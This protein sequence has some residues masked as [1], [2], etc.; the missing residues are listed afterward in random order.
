[1][2]RFFAEI[3]YKGIHFAGWQRQVNALTIQEVIETKLSTILNHQTTIVGCGRTDAGV[4]AA[5][6]FFHF[7][8]HFDP[9]SN[10]AYRLN[11]MVG[12]DIAV[13]SIFPVE[14]NLHA[15]FDA[16]SRSYT[17]YLTRQK[18]PFDYEIKTHYPYFD[19]IDVSKLHSTA[20]LI[21]Q[22]SEF[23]PFCKTNSDAETM[24]CNIME[25]RWTIQPEEY[26]YTI[27]A[28]RFLRGMVRLIVGMSIRVAIG[29][30]ELNEV[31]FALEKQRP[32][33]RSWSAPAEGLFL[34][35]V[36]YS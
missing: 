21:T 28:N 3:A 30:I 23:L 29:D 12:P 26:I 32:I 14:E 13:R 6:Y 33:M 15:R 20:S 10:L 8:T 17:Y 24:K 11:L 31:K 9:P 16:V 4:H 27:K 35:E 1:M 22:Y 2:S 36:L 18:S 19:K 25:S 7:E 5:Q 34:S